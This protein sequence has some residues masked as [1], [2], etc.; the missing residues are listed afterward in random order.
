VWFETIQLWAPALL[1]ILGYF[2]GRGA[3][4]RHYKEIHR[5]E[6]AALA[7]PMVT[8]RSVP[9]GRPVAEA[10]LVIGSVVVSVDYYKRFLLGLRALVGGEARGYASLIDR[11]RREA[12]LR[13]RESAPDADLFLNLRME[14]ATL[15]GSR[16]NGTASVEVVAYATA[17]RFEGSGA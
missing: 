15:F 8:S 11:A 7:V 5:R 9:P 4:R 10:N 13:L 6:E 14:T 3:E 2:A 16:T 17:V 1:L 12:M